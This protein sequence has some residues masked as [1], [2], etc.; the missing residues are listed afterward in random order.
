MPKRRKVSN[1]LGLQLLALLLE[2]SM[3]PYE[4]AALLRERGKEYDLK[5][6]WGSLYTVVQNLEKHEFIE[7]AE[8]ARE[9]RRP[10]RTVYRITEAG[11][12]E[13]IDWLREMIGTPEQE[14][15]RLR[16][17]LSVLGV[18]P[19]DEAIALLR[20]RLTILDADNAGQE[21]ALKRIENDVLRAFL[22]EAEYYLAIR[23]AEADWLRGLIAELVAGTMP[24]M[25]L[26]RDLHA[27]GRFDANAVDDAGLDKPG[28]D[29]PGLDTPGRP[30]SKRRP[31]EGGAR[32]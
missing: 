23:K 15:P 8:T 27:S 11:R 4:M 20:Q 13:L 18:L 12:E 19:P 5:I 9:G 24:G 10:E 16:T 17:A 25:D 31:R 3:H 29:K 7:A 14:Y 2:K 32:T 6:N 26:W 28:L 1:L 21:A 30:R 22:I